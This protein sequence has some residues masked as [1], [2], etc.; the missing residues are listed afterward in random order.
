MKLEEFRIKYSALTE[1]EIAKAYESKP[2]N[3]DNLRRV[4]MGYGMSG[5]IVYYGRLSQKHLETFEI[6]EDLM[7]HW[8]TNGISYSVYMDLDENT[9]TITHCHITKN[10][11][12]ERLAPTQQELKIFINIMEYITQ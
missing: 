3:R 4:A 5:A 1:I 9:N 10:N 7:N 11:K 8:L 2:Y 12:D 6:T